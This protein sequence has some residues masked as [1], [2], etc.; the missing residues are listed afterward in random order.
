M[1]FVMSMQEHKQI[2]FPTGPWYTVDGGDLTLIII[3]R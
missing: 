3:R 1:I 2:A